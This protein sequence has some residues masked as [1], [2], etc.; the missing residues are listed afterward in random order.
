ML[1]LLIIYPPFPWH[2]RVVPPVCCIQKTPRPAPREVQVWTKLPKV[3]VTFSIMPPDTLIQSRPN[4]LVVKKPV[5]VHIEALPTAVRDRNLRC[6]EVPPPVFLTYS[7]SVRPTGWHRPHRCQP[8][9]PVYYHLVRILWHLVHHLHCLHHRKSRRN[10][11]RKKRGLRRQASQV[12]MRR[13]Y[14]VQNIPAET[15]KNLNN[16]LSGIL[17]VLRGKIQQH[18]RKTVNW[19]WL[20]CRHATNERIYYRTKSPAKLAVLHPSFRTFRLNCIPYQFVTFVHFPGGSDT[21]KRPAIHTESVI[22]TGEVGTPPPIRSME[23]RVAGKRT[24]I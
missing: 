13:R 2:L 16:R 6:M 18:C 11:G 9:L 3:P 21:F 15:N 12:A 19:A 5:A 17:I 8:R 14:L 1:A 23:W 7:H 10:R 22:K 24:I 4:L 20:F